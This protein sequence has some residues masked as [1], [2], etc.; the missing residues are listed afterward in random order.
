MVYRYGRSYNYLLFSYHLICIGVLLFYNGKDTR[1]SLHGNHKWG[2]G[3]LDCSFST[4]L[5]CLALSLS[6]PNPA[7]RTGTTRTGTNLPRAQ[8]PRLR[9]PQAT[10]TGANATLVCEPHIC[11]AVHCTF[12]YQRSKTQAYSSYEIYCHDRNNNCVGNSLNFIKYLGHILASHD[13]FP[14][15]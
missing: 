7:Y 9:R 5:L 3:V 2:T 14:M 4:Y 6:G 1:Q 10:P 11:I 12:F 15:T 8:A 13:D